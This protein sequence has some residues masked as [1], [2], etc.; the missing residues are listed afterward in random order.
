MRI[1]STAVVST[2]SLLLV[3]ASCGGGSGS[4][5]GAGRSGQAGN[6][7]GGKGGA[8]GHGSGGGLAGATGTGGGGGEI[9]T[10]GSAGGIAG[11]PGAGGN[12]GASQAG[13]SAGGIAG[14]NGSGGT[15]GAGGAVVGSGGSGG[16]AGGGVA[17]SGGA[18]GGTCRDGTFANGTSCAPCSTCP[19]GQFEAAGCSATHD[20]VCAACTACTA[21]Q[22]QSAACGASTDTVCNGCDTD[23][24]DCT[25]IGAC[26][27]CAPGNYLMN[28]VCVGCSTCGPGEYQAAACSGIAD[29]VCVPCSTCSAGEFQTAACAATADTAC[30]ACST[31]GAGRFE[32]AACGATSD[33]ACATCSTCG[34]GQIAVSACTA[35]SDTT[36]RPCGGSGESCC[37]GN[38]CN[39]SLVCAGLAC[40]CLSACNTSTVMKG[41]GTIWI[42]GIELTN[43]DSSPF[44]ATSYSADSLYYGCATT[45]D[46]AVWCWSKTYLNND[47]QLGDGKTGALNQYPVQ[48]VTSVGGPALSGITSVNVNDFQPVGT[49]R[50]PG[51]TACALGPSGA[52]WCWGNGSSGQLGNG[53]LSNSYVAVPVLSSSGGAQFTG[54]TEI[55]VTADHVCALKSDMT[56]WCWGDNSTGQ[57]GVGDTSLQR[58]LYPV[59]V[60]ALPSAASHVVA[61]DSP[62]ATCASTI[63]GNAWCWG[64]SWAIGMQPTVSGSSSYVPVPVLTDATTPLSQVARIVD[65][66]FGMTPP[67]NMCALKTDGTLWCWGKDVYGLI[68]ASQLIDYNND[69]VANIEITGRACYLDAQGN[70]WQT[71][72]A[73]SPRLMTTRQLPN[74]VPAPCP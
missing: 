52:V 43:A 13:G 21:G 31:C 50:A 65:M 49:T 24:A 3:A 15:A 25:G 28:G 41:D 48:V 73:P 36:C 55:S 69:P 59:Q 34:A 7:I 4:E 29:T 12:A 74:Y 6:G 38:S 18:G 22:F 70:K 39:Q 1:Q 45:S 68:Y 27:T 2:L 9:A 30:T 64:A 57:L 32:T 37:G 14:A 5:G 20:T 54:V 72:T 19:S 67:S 46:S 35:T 62:G 42:L 44:T 33:T 47:G 58:A 17:G 63:D 40:G 23:C 8:A 11:A 60:T 56:V 51:G 61:T 53:S 10:G 66:T 71:V 16:T 26:T